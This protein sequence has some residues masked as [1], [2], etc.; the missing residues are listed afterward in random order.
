M[1]QYMEFQVPIIIENSDQMNQVLSEALGKESAI[2]VRGHG[3]Y[4]SADT[5]NNAML[6]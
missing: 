1:D 5:I 2:L 6:M 4:I 3:L